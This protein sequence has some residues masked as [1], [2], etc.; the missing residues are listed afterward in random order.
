MAN[1]KIIFR[2]TAFSAAAGKYNPEAPLDG[3]EDNFYVDDDL[4][5][6][7]LGRFQTDEDI[8]MSE[9]GCLM[10]VADGMGGMNAGEVASEIA[11]ETVKDFFAPGKI[12]PTIAESPIERRKYLEYVIKEADRRIKTDAKENPA[13]EGMGSTII[14][15]WIVGDTMTVSWCG[16]SRAYRFNPINGIELLSRDHSYVQELVN[17]GA[18]KYEDTFEHPQGNIVTRSLGD[19]NNAARPETKQFDVYNEDIILLCSDGLSGV[20]RD[21]KTKDRNGIY[22]PGENIEE[23]IAAHTSSMTECRDAL[24]DAAEKADW[25]DNV[26][27]L[28]CQIESGAGK[29]P[30]RQLLEQNNNG[31]EKDNHKFKSLKTKIFLGAG[32]VL[33]LVAIL[34]GAFY[35]LGIQ[36]GVSGKTDQGDIVAQNDSIRN[37][38]VVVGEDVI[39]ATGN[40]I[41]EDNS[42]KTVERKGEHN[43]DKSVKPES[44][45]PNRET[46]ANIQN[47]VPQWKAFLLAKLNRCSQPAL[48]NVVTNVRETINTASND[49]QKKCTDLVSQV[50]QRVTYLNMLRQYNGKLTR[51]GKA[52]FD[53]LLSEIGNPSEFHPEYWKREIP[54]LRQFLSGQTGSNNTELSPVNEENNGSGSNQATTDSPYELT[55]I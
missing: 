1:K 55:E 30:K 14:L 16:D 36:K 37:T 47:G 2:L 34:C 26:T 44:D 52:K 41:R 40:Q 20:L 4:N 18:L 13:H 23:I 15:A 50:E 39:E 11:I 7:I 45:A 3:N 51:K 17:Q 29:A 42:G 32:G 53:A 33:V 38:G 31:N 8:T 24:L 21:R 6:N 27:V 28:L 54:K 10:V 49:D 48:K 19:P 25:Y 5:D 35:Y 9:C 22:Y 46:S 43:E 12:S